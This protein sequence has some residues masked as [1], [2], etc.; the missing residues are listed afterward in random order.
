MKLTMSQRA[1]EDI[2]VFLHLGNPALLAEVSAAIAP[3][4]GMVYVNAMDN[5]A[6]A[7]AKMAF[8]QSVVLLSE[9]R[10]RDVGG[11]LR[12]IRLFLQRKDRARAVLFVHTKSNAA[13]RRQLFTV[14]GHYEAVVRIFERKRIGLVGSLSHLKHLDHLNWVE[15]NRIARKHGLPTAVPKFPRRLLSLSTYRK[16]NPDLAEHDDRQL[17]EH[18][19]SCGF[20][21]DRVFCRKQVYADDGSERPRYVAGTVFWM[22][23]EVLRNFFG[24]IDLDRE[25]EALEPGDFDNRHPTRTHAWER[26]FGLV[27]YAMNR[28]TVGL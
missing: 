28:T 11:Y 8:P 16:Y 10:G 4:R 17:L 26:I 13:W 3:L 25:I 27:P 19:D 14:I 5:R 20:L 22:D 7:A 1:R 2:A 15:V 9:N 23:A 12:L 18:F 24:K 6:A 21:E